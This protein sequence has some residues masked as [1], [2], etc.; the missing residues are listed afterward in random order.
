MLEQGGANLRFWVMNI[1]GSYRLHIRD[2]Q[3]R[4]VDAV[5]FITSNRC[6]GSV[7]SMT[8]KNINRVTEAANKNP[9]AFKQEVNGISLVK[10][11]RTAD[12]VLS[13]GSSNARRLHPFP[14]R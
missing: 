5:A 7:A 3:G 14:R 6:S 2:V 9:G 12:V 8:I 13:T 10:L 1:Q 4:F 11:L